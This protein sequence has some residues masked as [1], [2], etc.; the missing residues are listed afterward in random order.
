MEES[1]EHW[2]KFLKVYGL[3]QFYTIDPAYNYV[4][5]FYKG[6]LLDCFQGWTDNEI[7]TKL[8]G[9]D[10][11]ERG[12]SLTLP[13]VQGEDDAREIPQNKENIKPTRVEKLPDIN[14]V[15][16]PQRRSPERRRYSIEVKI[17]K[18]GSFYNGEVRRSPKKTRFVKRLSN[19][20][21]VTKLIL[22]DSFDREEALHEAE[23][24]PTPETAILHVTGGVELVPLLARRRRVG[25]RTLPSSDVTRPP[26]QSCQYVFINL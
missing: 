24:K 18:E 8:H 25:A 7:F 3:Y 11:R 12:S 21:K 13:K 22:D 16:S 14:Y 6:I 10:R 23:K 9:D 2:T 4:P 19:G 20:D 26:D 1:P 17:K 5:S 15:S